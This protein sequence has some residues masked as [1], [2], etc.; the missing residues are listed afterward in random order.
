M[1]IKFLSILILSGLSVFGLQACDHP[2]AMPTGYTYHHETFK[3]A[4]P[5]LPKSINDEQRDFM[6]STQAGQFRTA[7]Y[8]LLERLTM[9]AGMPPKPAYILAPVPMT[10]FYAN[11]DNDMRET[12]RYIGYAIA[13]M[14]T[15]AYVFTYEAMPV[16][17][18]LTNENVMLIIRVFDKI[19]KEAKIL[20]QESGQF[21]IQGAETL[22]ITS[23]N[24]ARLPTQAKISKQIDSFYRPADPELIRTAPHHN[25]YSTDLPR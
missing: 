7:V 13:D 6:D 22:T 15:G 4:A 5:P 9:R 2:N 11:I 16:D 24:Y 21:Y 25:G 19:G 12:M 8:Q 20:A 10:P 14:P 3:S 23:P 18:A 1:R 17:D